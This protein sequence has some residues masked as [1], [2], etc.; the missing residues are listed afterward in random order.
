MTNIA[1][2]LQWTT[3]PAKSRKNTCRQWTTVRDGGVGW[4]SAWKEHVA[5]VTCM[6]SR[7]GCRL[8]DYSELCAWRW[9][10]V[11]KLWTNGENK[12]CRAS[13]SSRE[14]HCFQGCDEQRTNTHAHIQTCSHAQP[15][16]YMQKRPQ[17]TDQHR[18][19]ILHTPNF[20]QGRTCIQAYMCTHTHLSVWIVVKELVCVHSELF[21]LRP[22]SFCFRSVVIWVCR[23]GDK[24]RLNTVQSG[25][26][27]KSL[28]LNF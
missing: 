13:L 15:G 14:G 22:Q 28:Q 1:L 17:N 7:A 26:T 27:E 24:Y 8:N 25:H 9:E 21:N 5:D 12:K 16:T 10:Q 23:R 6:L 3:W 20:A 11:G 19:F 18:L 2:R 4:R